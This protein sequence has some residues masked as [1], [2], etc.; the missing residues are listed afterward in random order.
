M[1]LV[2]TKSEAVLAFLQR[3]LEVPYDIWFPKR[4]RWVGLDPKPQWH[5][6]VIYH[7]G[8]TACFVASQTRILDYSL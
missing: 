1:E 2:P 8:L 5:I 6:K 4:G 3:M 7:D